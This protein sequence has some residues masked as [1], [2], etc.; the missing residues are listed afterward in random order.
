MG[1]MQVWQDVI[2][3]ADEFYGISIFSIS[4]SAANPTPA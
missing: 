4:R 3:L 2:K 1:I